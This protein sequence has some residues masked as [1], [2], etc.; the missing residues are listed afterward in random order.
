MSLV[1]R[2]LGITNIPNIIERLRKELSIYSAEY[3][4]CRE[5]I[6]ECFSGHYSKAGNVLADRYVALCIESI[7]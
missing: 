7:Q 1:K 4:D 6:S 2:L 5:V 3:L